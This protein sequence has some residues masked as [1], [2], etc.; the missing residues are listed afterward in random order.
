MKFTKSKRYKFAIGVLIANFIMF[1][2]GIL[3]GADLQSLGIGLAGVNT[4][5]IFYILGETYRPSKTKHEDI[6]N[7][8]ND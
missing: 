1:G 3:K 7:P 4:P 6:K 8:L 2:F 5:L